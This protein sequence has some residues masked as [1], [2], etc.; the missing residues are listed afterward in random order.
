MHLRPSSFYN[1]KE[2][3]TIVDIRPAGAFDKGSLRNA[4]SI[5][6]ENFPSKHELIHALTTRISPPVHLIDLDGSLAE[7]ISNETK[8]PFLLGGYRSFKQWRN[9]VFSSG[10]PVI[11]LGG[12]TGSGKTEVL[13]QLKSDGH[14]VLDLEA[15]ASHKGSVFGNLE[16]RLQPSHENFHNMLLEFW[17][18]Y[19]TNRPVW[20]EE[21]SHILG[22][23]GIPET[24]YEK[25]KNAFMVELDVSFEDRLSHIEQEYTT[26]NPDGFSNA[27]RKL[28]SR[29]GFSANHKALHYHTS[30]QTE[31][32]LQILLSYYDKA[33]EK[34]RERLQSGRMIHVEP[35]WFQNKEKVK[36]L[37]TEI[38]ASL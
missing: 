34:R 28:E 7:E 31:K 22:S 36:N 3:R 11:L 24:L 35:S 13:K 37:E 38:M 2:Q 5:P 4:I 25:M 23:T 15:L 30:G 29:M 6:I 19:N 16:N 12:R 14:Q 21:K 1:W 18:S 17:L 20:M 8:I 9:G 27:I 26:I 32:C 10:P 33:Y